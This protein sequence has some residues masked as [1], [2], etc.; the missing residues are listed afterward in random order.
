ME[1]TK[2]TRLDKFL[3]NLFDELIEGAEQYTHNGSLWMIFTDDRKWVFEFTESGTLWYNYGLFRDRMSIMSMDCVEDKQHI[4]KWF[5]DRFLNKPKVEDTWESSADAWY[6]VENTIE[7]G[8]KKTTTGKLLVQRQI[9]DTIQNGVKHTSSGPYLSSE[10]VE[11]TI[12]NGVKKTDFNMYRDNN[13]VEDTIQNGVKQTKSMLAQNGIRIKETI[14][15]G[16]KETRNN[17]LLRTVHV[18]NTIINGVKVSK[19]MDEWVNT[20]RIVDEVVKDG[21]KETQPLPAQDG[22]MDWG[23]YYHGKEDR[24]K[25]FN[26]YL[27]DAIR[28]GVKEVIDEKHH[29]TREVLITIKDGVKETYDD[30]S[31]NIARVEGIIRVG[32]KIDK[33]GI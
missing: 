6:Q 2:N 33:D 14:E 26:E 13:A 3:F 9:E 32:K 27:D 17:K 18:M 4:T 10:D 15:N 20:E 21:V 22:N 31:N 30:C 11:Y 5:E 23:N 25:P 29:R 8:V 24:T 7:N 28:F 19:P 16:V 12:Q 1:K